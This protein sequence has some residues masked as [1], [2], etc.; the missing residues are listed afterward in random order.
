M[1]LQPPSRP[2]PAA[3]TGAA[4]GEAQ[5]PAGA[6]KHAKKKRRHREL[7][8]E[9]DD[10][11]LLEENTGIRRARPA[12]HRRIKKARDADRGLGREGG[13]QALQE[14]LF[15]AE[16]EGEPK[17]RRGKGGERIRCWRLEVRWRVSEGKQLQLHATILHEGDGWQCPGHR[18]TAA[19][20]RG[21]A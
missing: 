21:H 16:L 2:M 3:G 18:S 17:K 13:A 9:D 19:A 4:E 15:G 6:A 5:P 10:Y 12:A 7:V 1:G 14:E 20:L 8:L 11:D